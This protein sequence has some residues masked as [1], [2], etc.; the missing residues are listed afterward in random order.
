LWRYTTDE[1]TISV[2][3]HTKTNNSKQ[4]LAFSDF[5]WS[6]NAGNYPDASEIADYID[7]FAE[8]NKLL[9]HCRLGLGIHYLERSEKSDQWDLTLKDK[10]GRLITEQFSRVL[11]TTGAQSRP[12]MPKFS[13][14]EHFKGKVIHARAFKDAKD[15]AGERVL[16]V[17]LSNTA[18]DVAAELSDVCP[19]V[20]ISHRSGMILVER[21]PEGQKPTDHL[22]TRRVNGIIMTV[23]RYFPS[24]ASWL[25]NVGLELKMK[26]GMKVKPEWGLLPAHPVGNVAPTMNDYILDLLRSGHLKSFPGISSISPDGHTVNFTNST[27][28]SNITTIILCTG[29]EPNFTF[30]G[31]SA[32]PTLHPSPEWDNHRNNPNHMPY[33]RLFRGLFP[34]T[35]HTTSLAFIG[36]YRGHNISAFVN[37]DL[38]SQAVTQV[39]KGNYVLPP[40]AEREAWCDEHY[41]TML[42]HIKAW[43]TVQVG[44]NAKQFERFLNDAAGNGINQKLGWGWE[45]WRFMLGNWKL[46]K[47][48]MDGVD[49]PFI[50][51]LFESPRR[52]K[53]RK[54][55]EGAEEWVY[56]TN[57]LEPPASK[58]EV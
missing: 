31:P 8:H 2:T 25:G 47:L 27:S 7:Q 39:W 33:P 3:K 4:R 6:K 35:T 13:G 30:L 32:N 19:E 28:V 43:R 50:L 5:P 46:Y 52:E 53:G 56:R 41:K 37:A 18:G 49:G 11:I 14:M 54:R 44:Q 24:L 10:D 38:A 9:P 26:Y 45:G 20:F 42:Q 16:I 36:A 1:Q 40:Q 58:K 22:A 15:F 21:T 17:G 34:P 55:W 51:R 57:G 23:N 12:V 48:L 29:Y